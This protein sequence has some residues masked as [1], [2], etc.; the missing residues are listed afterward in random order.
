MLSASGDPEPRSRSAWQ[1]VAFG[2]LAI[3][4]VWLPLALV[5][6]AATVSFGRFDQ[7]PFVAQLLAGT[8][9]LALAVAAMMGGLLVG[10]WGG[11]AAGVREA[12]LSGL[13]VAGLAVAMSAAKFGFDAGELVAAPIATGF[14]AIGGALGRRTKRP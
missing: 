3:L 13:A 12:A 7:G 6:V 9:A 11:P 14:A 10:R 2:A 4:V 8:S 5:G 1:W